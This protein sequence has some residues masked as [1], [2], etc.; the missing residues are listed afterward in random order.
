MVF[1]KFEDLFFNNSRRLNVKLWS[2]DHKAD[3][4]GQDEYSDENQQFYTDLEIENVSMEDP[5]QVA[6]EYP[7]YPSR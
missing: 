2:Q 7:T 1:A 4:E 6:N 5:N 3:N